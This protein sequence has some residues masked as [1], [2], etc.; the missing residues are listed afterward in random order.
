MCNS[1]QVTLGLRPSEQLLWSFQN[2]HAVR[3]AAANLRT[4]TAKPGAASANLA[5]GLGAQHIYIWMHD[6]PAEGGVRHFMQRYAA[7]VTATRRTL[8]AGIWRVSMPNHWCC[9]LCAGC[10]WTRLGSLCMTG[11]PICK[12][13]I[14]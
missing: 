5:L 4:E 13:L 10:W 7:L 11:P 14:R 3:Q 8:D 2:L 1:L 6:T 12:T 9:M